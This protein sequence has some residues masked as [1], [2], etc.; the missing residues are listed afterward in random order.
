MMYFELSLIPVL[1]Y[2]LY[3]FLGSFL[4]SKNWEKR[5]V[6]LLLFCIA[7]FYYLSAN[8]ILRFFSVIS[9][10]RTILFG[11]RTGL[12]IYATSLPYKGSL[13]KKIFLSILLFA[14]NSVIEMLIS[15]VLLSIMEFSFVEDIPKAV[16]L[17][18]M[19][20]DIVIITLNMLVLF[21]T[22]LII[23][24]FR[25][26]RTITNKPKSLYVLELLIPMVNIFVV[27][28]SF[29]YLSTKA[30][31]IICIFAMVVNIF[32]YVVHNWLEIY[33]EKTQKHKLINQRYKMYT[34]YYEN[35]EQQQTE[36][37]ITKHDLKNKL[38]VLG[39]YAEK[40]EV[41]MVQREIQVIRNQLSNEQD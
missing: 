26:K 41:D 15:I 4:E 29:F 39:A 18:D 2:C 17:S 28:F 8:I 16:L 37:R 25:K 31:L 19:D 32:T 21:F 7:I 3:I 22:I 36:I 33:Y 14:I 27:I 5:K 30:L 24:L 11:L 40:G 20:I 10:P 12:T 35:L 13:P 9:V 6:A 34:E 38:I 1:I 23:R